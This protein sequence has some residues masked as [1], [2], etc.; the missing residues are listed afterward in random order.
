VKNATA[1]GSRLPYDIA[2]AKVDQAALPQRDL[3]I[4]SGGVVDSLFSPSQITPSLQLWC[5]FPVSH[6]LSGTV[7]STKTSLDVDF[8]GRRIRF[9]NLFTF[10]SQ[11]R[12]GDSGGLLH[13]DGSA[14]G[15]FVAVSEASPELGFFQ[16]FQDALE[17]LKG[18]S[19]RFPITLF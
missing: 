17:Y 5:E 3:A 1:I 8:P 6:V 16:P 14:V 18:L 12:Q 4:R 10:H 11:A 19:P 7:A 9:E 15:I 13:R 2:L